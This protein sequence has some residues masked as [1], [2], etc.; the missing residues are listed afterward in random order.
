MTFFLWMC[1]QCRQ[2]RRFL[3]ATS[4]FAFIYLICNHEV[5]IQAKSHSKVANFDNFE[6]SN[7]EDVATLHVSMQDPLLAVEVIES[8]GNRPVN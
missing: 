2:L 6:V 5:L 1:R 4:M 3:P 8:A 7:D